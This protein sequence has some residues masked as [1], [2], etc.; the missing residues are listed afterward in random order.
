MEVAVAVVAGIVVV[1]IV[2][3]LVRRHGSGESQSVVGYRQALDVLGQ[4][5]GGERDPGGQAPPVPGPPTAPLGRPGEPALGHFDDVSPEPDEGRST[6]GRAD[7]TPRRDRSLRV[8][9]RPARRIGAPL[10]LLVVVVVVA[11]GAA[12]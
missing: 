11:G 1:V 3:A 10:V 6:S 2:S 8:M 4:V 7:R 12:Y 9:E 5:A